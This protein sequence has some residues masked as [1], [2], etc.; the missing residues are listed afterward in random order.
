MITKKKRIYLCIERTV[1]NSIGY[2]ISTEGIFGGMHAKYICKI[3]IWSTGI[4]RY[5]S[6][7]GRGDVFND[8]DLSLTY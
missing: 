3:I 8:K 1:F 7:S 2:K 6:T 4:Q 5:M